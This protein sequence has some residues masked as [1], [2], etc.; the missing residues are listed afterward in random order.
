MGWGNFVTI[1]LQKP[2][3]SGIHQNV[4]KYNVCSTKPETKVLRLNMI[5]VWN[6]SLLLFLLCVFF[7]VEG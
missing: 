3:M 5:W 2:V 4:S 7:G 6:I 1:F